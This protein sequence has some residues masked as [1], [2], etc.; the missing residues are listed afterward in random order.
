MTRSTS[1]TTTLARDRGH[2]IS[3][4]SMSNLMPNSVI[5]KPPNLIKTS[6]SSHSINESQE[7]DLLQTTHQHYCVNKKETEN[8]LQESEETLVTCI[9]S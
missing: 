4:K 6:L 8:K 1:P 2:L 5:N 3:S 7:T 9:Y